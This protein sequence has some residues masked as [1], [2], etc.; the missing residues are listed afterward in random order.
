M[1]VTTVALIDTDCDP[2]QVD[3]PIPANDDAMKSVSLI[4]GKLIDSVIE[5]KAN[6]RDVIVPPDDEPVIE[7]KKKERPGGRRGGPGGRRG[8]PGG[9]GPGGRGR[10]GD[11]KDEAPKEGAP[12]PAA[13]GGGDAPAPEAPPAGD[14]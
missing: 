10:G 12:A 11:R 6:M 9:G 14:S 4:L 3:I 5:G 13:E 8:G 2:D 1:G 7:M